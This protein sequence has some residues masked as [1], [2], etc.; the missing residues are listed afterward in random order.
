MT[1]TLRAAPA[2]SFPSELAAA[3]R[4]VAALLPSGWARV[5]RPR[6][7][8]VLAWLSLC[9]WAA[10][11]AGD[12]YTTLSMMGTGLFEEGNAVA[13]AGMNLIGPAGYTVAASVVCAVFAVA[14]VGRRAGRYSSAA[15]WTL[16]GLGALKV[17]VALSN[18]LLWASL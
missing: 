10:G 15:G 6:S 14:S 13:A 17:G 11:T 2:T 16:M 8:G 7:L 1:T 5:R 18:A 3:A 4:Q 9:A 12:A